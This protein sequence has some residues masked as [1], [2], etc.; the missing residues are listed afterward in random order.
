MLGNRAVLG[1]ALLTALLA[2]PSAWG[3]SA[4]VSEKLLISADK[5]YT[6]SQGQTH[7]IEV[8]GPV[9]IEMDQVSL[10]ADQAVIWLWPQSGG[11]LG[12]QQADIVLIGNASLT[13]TNNHLSRSGTQLLVNAVVRGTIRITAQRLAE[14]DSA[15]ALFRR[16][17]SIRAS[18]GATSGPSTS[19]AT[20]YA[21]FPGPPPATQPGAAIINPTG[22][23]IEF[24]APFAEQMALADDTVAVVLSGG[25]TLTQ[26][27][28]NGDFLELLAGRIVLFTSVTTA[29]MKTL[30]NLSNVG[31]K[32]TAAYLEDDVR[33]NFTP[34]AGGRAEQRLTAD[35]AYYDFVHDRAVLTG[36]V[37]HTLD[38][39]TQLPVIVRAEKMHQLAQGEFTAEHV[40]MTT[41][42][43]ATP[44]I[45]V[46][47]SDAYVHQEVR[48]SGGEDNDFV[49]TNDTLDF[50]GL[51]VFYLPI[52]A[53]TVSSDPFPLRALSTQNSQRFG[54]GFTSQWGLFET[55]G[56]PHPKDLDLSFRLDDF[57]R[58]GLG[59][60]LDALYGGGFITPTTGQPW[61]FEG[62][63]KSYIID[64]RGIDQLGGDRTNV[65][66][67]AELRGRVLWEHQHF[68]P[69]DWQVQIRA[70]YVSDPT[71]LE[72]Y[73]QPD[74]D[75]GMPY[76]ASFYVKRQR[77]TEAL[78]FLG[79]F[80]TTPFITNADRQ[81]EQFDI[82][83]MPEIGYRRIGDSL[84][85]DHLSFF[86][87]NSASR[88][89]FENSHASLLQQGFGP[90]L[91][92]GIASEGMTGTPGGP[93][94]RADSRQELDWP[95]A[96]GQFKIVP[97]VL[98]RV[99]TYSNSPSGDAQTRLYSGGGFR[100]A[101][102]FWKIDDS[103][104]SDLFDIHRIRTVIQPEVNL[105]AAGTTLDRSKLFIYDQD[106]D[107][108]NDIAA[109]Q[110]AW[111]QRWQTQR[112]GPGEWRSVD[113]L[114]L[115]VEGNFF[116]NQPPPGILNPVQFRGLYFPSMPETSIP[117]QGV[118]ADATWHLSDTTAVLSD[119]QWNM[120]QHELAT[121]S[122]GIAV[123][124]EERITYFIDDRY[125]QV[126]D[127]Q[128]L[129]FSVAYQLTR[130]Y[131]LQFNQ[132]FN[133]GDTHD[134][135]TNLTLTRQF[136]TFSI[137]VTVFHDAVNNQSGFNVNLIP[138]NLAGPPRGLAGLLT[139][140]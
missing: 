23:Q 128:V 103:A 104:E 90:G 35:R 8:P 92:P 135:S 41:S 11:L 15:S 66:P 83:R 93:V 21:P 94:Y 22:G 114:E 38:P 107:G 42:S 88:L 56:Q 26:A 68:F 6:W 86:S 75:D 53:G 74:F 17:V 67:P 136:D 63:F 18:G 109:A 127:S 24:H 3:Q 126:L 57:S 79:E 132:S 87:D 34:A 19:P 134:I 33:I 32:I 112:G 2:S 9:T 73:Y 46:R 14:D 1:W 133:F 97:Y 70:G 20:Q 80:D 48:P 64:D 5:A 111:H 105:F 122:A 45:S 51:P 49:A 78:T 72:E 58:R 29:Q 96:A 98:G 10:A 110:F 101:T 120:D 59:T 85:D 39:K 12:E 77:D 91:S 76:D 130:K 44:S 47:A 131:N 69:D 36:V 28:D 52:A 137:A 113:F 50:F 60:G 95:F 117:R 37:L 106:V 100:I 124:R 27:R 118:N 84:L 108:V 13:A 116:A 99:T 125:I 16:A 40:E 71:F 102:A 54:T 121:A 62:D 65:Q 43:F 81:Q 140:Q 123:L 30:G 7:V 4:S 139:P 31:S 25:V 61:N 89:S 129:S 119:A 138:Q 115:N 55:L 82:Q